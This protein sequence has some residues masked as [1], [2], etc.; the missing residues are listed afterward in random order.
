[1]FI[2]VNAKGQSLGLSAYRSARAARAA[3]RSLAMVCGEVYGI[4][5]VGVR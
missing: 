4:R 1:M 3:A 2:I 5:P